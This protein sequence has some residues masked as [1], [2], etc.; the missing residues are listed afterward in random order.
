VGKELVISRSV[1]DSKHLLRFCITLQCDIDC[2]G[3]VDQ[4]VGYF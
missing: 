2:L 3:S 4:G 1:V